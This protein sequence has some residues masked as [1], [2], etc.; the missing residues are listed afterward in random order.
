MTEKIS[1]QLREI[2]MTAVSE[3]AD[4]IA[5]CWLAF[6]RYGKKVGDEYKRRKLREKA[7]LVLSVAPEVGFDLE[8]VP[9]IFEPEE[10]PLSWRALIEHMHAEIERLTTEAALREEIRLARMKLKRIKS[11]ASETP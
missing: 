9:D 4:E 10:S 8:E 1:D 7:T 11:S 5:D 3:A 2:G 6:V